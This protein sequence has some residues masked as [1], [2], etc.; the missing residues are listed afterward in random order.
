MVF[1]EA[2]LIP[3]VHF[4]ASVRVKRLAVLQPGD[5]GFGKA[6]CHTHEAGGTGSGSG[7]ALRP[8]HK[9][10][11]CYRKKQHIQHIFLL[12]SVLATKVTCCFQT[13][14]STV[15]LAAASVKFLVP[16]VVARQK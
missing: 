2:A 14:P 12:F 5:L 13:L 4:D 3:V 7:H 8:L 15:M 6:L 10:R 16:G 11:R 9:R 1:H